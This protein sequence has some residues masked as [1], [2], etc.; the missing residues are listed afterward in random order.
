M[1]FKVGSRY[2]QQ[3]KEEEK[4]PDLNR[5]LYFFLLLFENIIK[6]Q[7]REKSGLN[8]QHN[9][10]IASLTVWNSKNCSPLKNAFYV[11]KNRYFEF[12]F[13]I[14]IQC[15][16]T[17]LDRLVYYMY[18]T[19]VHKRDFLWPSSKGTRWSLMIIFRRKYVTYKVLW[20][21]VENGWFLD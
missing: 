21:W 15:K 11:W 16:F 5:D 6:L 13:E 9:I 3:L 10:K 18:R 7:S 19:S 14:W 8:V 12:E 2:Q 20:S 17:K 4:M 1:V